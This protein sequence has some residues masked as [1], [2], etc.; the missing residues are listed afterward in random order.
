MKL[1]TRLILSLSALY[2]AG[3]AAMAQDKP[4]LV[5]VNYSLQY[6]A[7]QLLENAAEVVYPVPEGT[8]PSFWRPS[9]TDISAVQSADMILLNGAGFASWTKKV[10]LPRSR[11]VQTTRGLEDQFITTESI[12]HSHGDGGEHS[13]EGKAAYTW[14]DPMFAEAQAQAIAKGLKR[15]GL[16]DA[17]VID[18]NMEALSRAFT[19]LDAYAWQTLKGGKD[20]VLVATHPRY[21]Y[22]ARAYGLKIL[23]LEWEA[24]AMPDDSQLADLAA[25]VADQNIKVLLWEAEPPAAARQAIA[26]MG[27]KDVVFPTLAIPPKDGDLMSIYKQAVSD[28]GAVLNTD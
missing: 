25:L 17:A 19:D 7:E 23:S 16:A 20:I 12:T 11:I 26:A 5:S 22:L 6:M 9:V 24:G 14:M 15:R 1:L 10:S 2:W 18:R 28:L 3:N 13:H 27:L 21:Q 4:R 8:D